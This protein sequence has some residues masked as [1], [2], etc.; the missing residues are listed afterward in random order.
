FS[1]RRAGTP[2]VVDEGTYTF[3]RQKPLQRVGVASG[4]MFRAVHKDNDGN[5]LTSF[6]QDQ[7][8]DQIHVAAMECC[9][10]DLE[11]DPVADDAMEPNL[12]GCTARERYVVA[13][14]T[15]GPTQRAA[16]III[17]CSVQDAGRSIKLP[18]AERI[19]T[20]GCD[21]DDARVGQ[22]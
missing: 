16:P 17:L 9:I 7:T 5:L 22:L 15:V 14:G 12:S 1:S 8:T 19:R 3:S 18:P 20:V 11:R 4:V 6:R 13:V 2:F 10:G 21:V